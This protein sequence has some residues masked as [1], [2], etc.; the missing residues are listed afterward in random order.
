VFY[1]GYV[2]PDG[3]VGHLEALFL[4]VEGYAYAHGLVV[5]RQHFPAQQCGHEGG[6]ALLPVNQ[7]ALARGWGAV[8]EPH[9][10]I[11][12]SDQVADRVAL[13]ERIEEVADFGR[14]PDE[15]ALDFRDGDF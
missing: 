8:L 14:F 9:G 5:L 15:R 10:R 4:W 13:V 3:R 11:S 1:P 12:P 7:D 6:D 2:L